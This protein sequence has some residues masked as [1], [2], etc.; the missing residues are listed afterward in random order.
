MT[1]SWRRSRRVDP[2]LILVGVGPLGDD[3]DMTRR[4]QQTQR[5]DTGVSPV[6]AQRWSD[7]IA[8]SFGGSDALRQEGSSRVLTEPATPAPPRTSER[9]ELT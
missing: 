7:G 2:A 1:L 4:L 6:H 5:S 9:S 3:G 8:R